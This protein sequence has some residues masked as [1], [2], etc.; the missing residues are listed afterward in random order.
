MCRG[1]LRR[2]RRESGREVESVREN[3]R[4]RR[5]ECGEVTVTERMW[6]DRVRMWKRER[7]KI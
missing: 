6:E 5:R 1:D 4:W 7:L 2:R 3:V